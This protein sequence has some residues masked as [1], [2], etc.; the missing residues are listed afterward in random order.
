MA[1]LQGR[2]VSL[3]A[4]IR[5]KDTQVAPVEDATTVGIWIT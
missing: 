1:P 4:A 5:N 3:H 2:H